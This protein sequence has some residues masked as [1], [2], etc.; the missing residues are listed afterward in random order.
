MDAFI[1]LAFVSGAVVGAMVVW[2]VRRRGTENVARSPRRRYGWTV[3]AI[4]AVATVAVTLA[5]GYAVVRWKFRARPVTK[6]SVSDAVKQFRE[7]D[8]TTPSGDVLPG[9]VVGGPAPGVYSYKG[10]GFYELKVP[11]VG[12]DKRV[13]LAQIPATLVHIG[14]CWELTIQFFKQHSWSAQYCKD[15]AGTIVMRFWRGANQYFG[16]DV[17]WSYACDPAD[18]V[19]PKASAGNSWKQTCRPRGKPAEKSP[20]KHAQVTFIRRE[21]VDIAGIKTPAIHVRRTIKTSGDQTGATERHLW[22]SETNGLLLR[23]S[24][25][26]T[27]TGMATFRSD[28][29]VV[30]SSTTPT[31]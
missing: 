23:L 16:R 3:A 12:A 9:K 8:K 20:P 27:S 10:S 1:P 5:T 22:F 11:V 21:S 15:A 29:D 14:A 6:V 24:E 18:M 19:R 26:S 7:T 30:L 2:V 28:W 31:R 13:L 17:S 4:T 25:K